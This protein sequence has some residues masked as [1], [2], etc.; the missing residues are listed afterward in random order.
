MGTGNRMKAAIGIYRGQILM[1]NIDGIT[2]KGVP[3]HFPLKAQVIPS[4]MRQLPS[5]QSGWYGYIEVTEELKIYK[6]C[7]YYDMQVEPLGWPV[8]STG[9]AMIF[10]VNTMYHWFSKTVVDELRNHYQLQESGDLLLADG[11]VR[12]DIDTYEKTMSVSDLQLKSEMHE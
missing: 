8:E 6:E 3:S 9:D 7:Y 2:S 10:R 12:M 11:W 1:C 5:P 4:G